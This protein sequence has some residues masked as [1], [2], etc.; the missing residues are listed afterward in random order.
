MIFR[1]YK[2]FKAE[3]VWMELNNTTLP[4]DIKV[5][6]IIDKWTTQEGYPLIKATRNYENNKVT[7]LQ[8]NI[9]FINFV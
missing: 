8:V 9:F 4:E 1:K 7:I 5:K 6:D 2:S 3:N